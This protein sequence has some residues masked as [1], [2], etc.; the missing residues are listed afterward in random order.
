MERMESGT[1]ILL[2]R[3]GN[4]PHAASCL[5]ASENSVTFGHKLGDMP[6]KLRDVLCFRIIHRYL[7]DTY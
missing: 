5:I 6:K 1:E 4:R 2:Q 3:H 7:A